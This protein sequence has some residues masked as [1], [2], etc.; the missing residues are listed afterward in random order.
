[1][2]SCHGRPGKHHAG[3]RG[4]LGSGGTAG[5]RLWNVHCV[6]R[7]RLA[8]RELPHRCAVR[9]LNPCPGHHRHGSAGS[10][11]GDLRRRPSSCRAP[12][13]AVF[14]ERTFLGDRSGDL[15]AFSAANVRNQ[16]TGVVLL[17]V[18]DVIGGPAAGGAEALA[19]FSPHA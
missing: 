17:E 14:G 15:G 11:H 2:G 5:E 10:R 4:G 18:G 8:G 1:M 3:R 16:G 7:P 13:A 6:L 19:L 12:G 9:V